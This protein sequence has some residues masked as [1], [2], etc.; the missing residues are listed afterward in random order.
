AADPEVGMQAD[1]D[2]LE[3][4]LVGLPGGRHHLLAVSRDAADQAVG[5]DDRAERPWVDIVAA[6]ALG[7]PDLT[8][9]VHR[10]ARPG[11]RGQPRRPAI[12]VDEAARQV[13][14]RGTLSFRSRVLIDADAWL[15][16]VR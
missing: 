13:G 3:Q 14:L 15:S 9:S 1:D 12:H 7:A 10:R 4:F 2:A 8:G 6:D 5:R 16:P 11:H